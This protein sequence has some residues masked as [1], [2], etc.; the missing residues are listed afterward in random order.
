MLS[1]YYFF[2]FLIWRTR[3]CLRLTCA[4][5]RR[6]L[7]SISNFQVQLASLVLSGGLFPRRASGF[8]FFRGERRFSISIS[9]FWLGIGDA[10]ILPG[11]L[12]LAFWLKVCERS[13][14]TSKKLK[15]IKRRK[16]YKQYFENPLFKNEFLAFLRATQPSIARDFE[17][18][19]KAAIR[20][21]VGCITRFHWLRCFWV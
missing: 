2:L 21:T 8:D 13:E 20:G 12:I 16:K 19:L 15:V 18:E 7:I 4:A 1:G 11:H 14:R 5:R 3:L 10:P 6:N 17:R 9:Y